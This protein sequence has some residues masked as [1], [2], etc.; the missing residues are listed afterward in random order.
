MPTTLPDDSVLFRPEPILPTVERQ[1]PVVVIGMPRSG[2]TFLAHVI[3]TLN[4]WYVFDDLYMVQEAIS[5]R[6]EGPLT[7]RQLEHLT[8]FLGWSV[9][10]R[11]RFEDKFLRPDCTW[12]DIDRM[13]EVV[14][15]MYADRPVEW[16]ELQEEWLMR[17]ALHHGR[18]RWGWKTPQDFH[19]IAWLQQLY[20]GVRFV[21]IL[22]DPTRMMASFK[23]L[24][25]Q[26]GDKGQY[27]PLVYARYW[28][29]AVEA[30]KHHAQDAGV[31]LLLIK[32]EDLTKDPDGQADRI[33]AFLD[34]TRSG[35]VPVKGANTTFA[36]GKRRSITPTE[37]WLLKRIAGPL[38]EEFGYSVPEAR[39]RLRDLPDL[40]WISLR[41][42]AHQVWRL[43]K[44]ARSRAQVRAF[45][46]AWFQP[47]AEGRAG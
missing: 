18:S 22:R 17:L 31:P 2:S 24:T 45:L 37:Q 33:A 44:H 29:M 47:A 12:E 30:Y 34:A 4:E 10:A 26:D 9:R 39:F 36:G 23:F 42:A 20:P 13:V 43:R 1:P 8:V 27:H 11:I 14:Q 25:G 6:A 35:P 46:R 41:F 3:T 21:F 40:A 19:H 32:F 38:M 16:Q 5:L 15:A 28:R 7:P